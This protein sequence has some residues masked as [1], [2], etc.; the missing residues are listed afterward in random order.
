M[1]LVTGLVDRFGSVIC[2][3]QRGQV[4]GMAVDNTVTR[5]LPC[6]DCGV[7]VVCIGGINGCSDRLS[8]DPPMQLV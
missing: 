2:D 8:L 7:S 3:P 6:R 4:V 1:N 5:A